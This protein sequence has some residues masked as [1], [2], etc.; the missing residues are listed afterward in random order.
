MRAFAVLLL[1]TLPCAALAQENATSEYTAHRHLGIFVRADIGVG[2]MHFSASENGSTGS[3]SSVSIP[4]AVA[5][6]GA[7]SENWILGAELW[8]AYGPSPKITLD[9]SSASPPDSN[10]FLGN[11]G[12]LIVHYFMPANVYLSFAPGI[13]RLDLSFQGNTARTNYG[14]G[15]KLALGKEWWVSDHWG[16][17]IAV[18]GLFSINQDTGP[19]PPT[20]MTFGG[21]LT[22]SA[23][24]N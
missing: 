15:A 23:T 24:L 21:G 4:L 14:F 12:L 16:L 7:V 20:W 6:G 18:E 13:S 19:S 22:F 11:L 17:G 9:S 2:Y 1:A 8:F 10:M 5:V 3:V